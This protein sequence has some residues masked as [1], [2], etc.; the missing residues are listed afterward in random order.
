MQQAMQLLSIAAA[1]APV[2]ARQVRIRAERGQRERRALIEQARQHRAMA[3][4][5]G[6]PAHDSRWLRNA[7]LLDTARVWGAA[8]PYAN[9]ASRWFDPTAE[10]AMHKCEG[11]LRTLHPHAMARYDRLRAD[12]LTPNEAMRQSAPLF[13]RPPNVRDGTWS[14][15][16]SL[17]AGDGL[18][19]SWAA[20]EH[21]PTRAEWEAHVTADA[22]TQ[23]A[24]EILQEAQD[25][26]RTRRRGKL[27]ETE[28]R[29]RLETATNLPPGII[30]AAVRR[31][32]PA[33]PGNRRSS[34]PWAQDFPMPIDQVLAV[35]AGPGSADPPARVPAQQ[36]A[37]RQA[38]RRT[39][40]P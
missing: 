32:L 40:H 33:R 23:R 39:P 30:N 26:A 20:A 6:A 31:D 21:G 4:I 1:T 19:H 17:P 35:V 5:R 7:D 12:G 18:G 10:T 3:R 8:V 24:R 14:P 2:I 28:Q 25:Q 29:L 9:R 38:S 22:Q 34:K 37:Q 16:S 27:G 13:K 36:P 15:R 11:R